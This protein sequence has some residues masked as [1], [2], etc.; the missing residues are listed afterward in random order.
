MIEACLPYA[1]MVIVV[2]SG[3]KDGLFN[4]ICADKNIPILEVERVGDVQ[5]PLKEIFAQN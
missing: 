2:K 5:E 4:K 1:Q 3:N